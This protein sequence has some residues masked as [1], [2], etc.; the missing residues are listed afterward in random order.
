MTD[1]FEWSHCPAEFHTLILSWLSFQDLAVCMQVSRDWLQAG[2]KVEKSPRLLKERYWLKWNE[3]VQFD[4]GETGFQDIELTKS[5]M[6]EE[7]SEQRVPISTQSQ[8]EA[9]P[10]AVHFLAFCGDGYGTEDTNQ[11]YPTTLLR[12]TKSIKSSLG[13]KRR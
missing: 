2:K 6:E 12:S 3:F 8:P 4:D 11:A 13:E 7:A 9:R 5:D 10:D 1:S